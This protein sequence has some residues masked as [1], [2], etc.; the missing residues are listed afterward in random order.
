MIINNLQ[1]TQLQ[2]KSKRECEEIITPAI[3]EM[4]ENEDKLLVYLDSILEETFPDKEVLFSSYFHVADDWLNFDKEAYQK[5]LNESGIFGLLII[6]DKDGCDIDKLE[7]I[8]CIS[9][10]LDNNK[11][12]IRGW[13][14]E[15]G[16]SEIMIKVA[17]ALNDYI[18]KSEY[19]NA[20]INAI[21]ITSWFEHEFE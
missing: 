9:I 21:I 11:P 6:S 10:D 5:W 18:G 7:L 14:A 20:Y 2:G 17:E 3:E 15:N 8:G 16:N 1:I 4:Q 19:V 13:K 12:Y